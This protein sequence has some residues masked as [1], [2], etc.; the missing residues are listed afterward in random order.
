MDARG[1]RREGEGLCRALRSNGGGGGNG[2]DL[3]FKAGPGGATKENE[4]IKRGPGLS[5][6]VGLDV[7]KRGE[8]DEIAM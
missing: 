7:G 3:K 6:M 8:R 4:E 1:R 2:F 5:Y